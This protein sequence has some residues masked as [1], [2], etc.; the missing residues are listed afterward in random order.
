MTEPTR[1]SAAQQGREIAARRLDP[2]DLTEAYLDAIANDP[3]A[4]LIYARTT[5][6]RARVE[7]QAA[8]DRQ[9][10]GALNGPLDGVPLAWKDNVD[11]AGIATEAGSR[12]LAGRVPE[13]DAP[14]LGRAT[15]A[16]LVC[17]GKTHMSELAFSGLGVNPITATPP[18]AFDALRA[19][20]GSSSGSAVAA[21][22]GLASAAIGTDTGGSVRIPAVWNGLV[23]LKPGR[24]RVPLGGVVPLAESLDVV[25]PLARSAEDAALL[26]GVLA[27][28]PRPVP[29][30]A[31]PDGIALLAARGVVDEG[32]DAEVVDAFETALDALGEAGVKIGRAE[33]PEFARCLETAGEVSAIVNSEGWRRWGSAIEANPGVMYPMIEA[34]FRAGA[35][36]SPDADAQARA[37]YAELARAVAGRIAETGPIALPAVACMPPPVE[38]LLADE[39]YYA[40]RNLLA[41]R[42][43]RLANLL[44]LPAITVPLATPSTGLMLFGAPGDE[45]R[46]LALARG[47]EP[48]LAG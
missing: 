9:D 36:T 8:R 42:N 27:G 5:P 32:C 11:S 24:G 43:T 13:T 7:A 44:D 16:G 23:G 1:L 48:L 14:V 26:L 2:R 10:T 28:D 18:N 47:L 19:P 21:A 20:G 35:E 6:E 25:G 45:W 41:L 34:R 17:L 31:E 22:L 4:A 12:L 37:I 15:A 38:R 40:E 39:S 3:D 29:E 46:L 33:V 30:A